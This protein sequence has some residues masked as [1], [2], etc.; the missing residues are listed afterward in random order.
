MTLAEALLL[1]VVEGLTEFLPVSST[2]HLILAAD[3]LNLEGT[4]VDDYVVIC[5]FGAILA[6]L[7]FYF[8]RVR[9]VASGILTGEEKGRRLALNLLVAF[10][11]AA[12]V[13]LLLGDVIEERLFSA[14]TVAA[15]LLVGGIV[16]IV[17]EQWSLR[18]GTPLRQSV[19]DLR[20]RDALIIGLAQCLSLWPGMSRSMTTIVGAQLR[21]CSNMV[22]AEF[23]F[24]LALPTLGAATV[25]KFLSAYRSIV[26]EEGAMRLI[27]LGN[28]ASFAVALL[29]IWG[30][31]RLVERFGMTP[32]GVYRILLGL[33]VGLL[34]LGGRF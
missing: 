6:V 15:A 9:S 10:I 25:Y 20:W 30:F 13:G 29:A 1:S 24:L 23:S 4:L 32:F 31:I 22:A 26:A 34:V 28:G 19:D 5:Q 7:V 16:M 11:P 18:R 17:S 33:V 14:G 2:G 3:L 8:H 21:G 27:L 12:V